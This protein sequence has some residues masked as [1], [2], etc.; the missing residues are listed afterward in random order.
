MTD[1]W[2]TLSVGQFK[3]LMALPDGDDEDRYWKILAILND[4]TVEDIMT[5]PLQEVTAMRENCE[6][7]NEYPKK[8]GLSRHIYELG[9][10]KYA[11]TDHIGSITLAQYVDYTNTEDKPENMTELLAIMLVP[12]GHKYNDGYDVDKVKADIDAYLSVWDARAITGF[13]LGSFIRLVASQRRSLRKALRKARKEGLQTEEAERTLKD[14]DETL[15]S[16][17]YS[18]R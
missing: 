12:D 9:D 5:R 8:V 11:F 15:K 18:G 1:N 14:L 16:M 13:F 17:G 4:T 2:K 6:F 3:K 7:L 10:T